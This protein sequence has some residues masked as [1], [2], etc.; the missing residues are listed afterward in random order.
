MKESTGISSS[1][2]LHADVQ[3][4]NLAS[5]HPG[6]RVRRVE[7]VRRLCRWLW[8]EW[9]V[10]VLLLVFVLVPVKSS[11]ADWNWVPTGSMNPTI[12]EGDL[13]YVNKLAYDLRVP[14]TLHRLASWSEPKRGDI[15][16]CLSPED[17]TRLV[18]RVIDAPGDTIEMRNNA[19]FLNGRPLAYDET[20]TTRP[21]RLPGGPEATGVLAL[22]DLGQTVHPVISVP[23]I[24]ALRNFGPLAVPPGSYFVMGDNRDLSRDSRYFG[25]VPRASILGRAGAVVLSFDITDKFEPRLGRF[26]TQLQ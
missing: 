19:L 16:V 17:G 1:A 9:G 13:I 18:K 22:E 15:V 23:G 6:G 11:L 8:R 26:L 10:T 7:T 20:G 25:L 21:V 14:L 4:Q 3:T 2:G 12:L 5:P 24:S